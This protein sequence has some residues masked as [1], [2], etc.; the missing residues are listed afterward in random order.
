MSTSVF[1]T[2]NSTVTIDE[3]TSTLNA[4]F[5]SSNFT[6]NEARESLN[7]SFDFE[8]EKEMERALYYSVRDKRLDNVTMVK[9]GTYCFN[10][11]KPESSTPSTKNDNKVEMTTIIPS[12]IA[13][14]DNINP[15]QNF[16][17]EKNKTYVPHGC[18]SVI[19]KVIK[20]NAFAPMWI[21]G[22]PGN[23]KT[24]GVEQACAQEKRELILVN[25][26]N[27]TTEEDLIGSYILKDGSLVW[28]DGPVTVAMRRGAVLLLDE[29][30]QARN[31]VMCLN[32]IL[33]NKPYFIKKTNEVVK[34]QEG[35]CVIATANTKGDGTGLDKFAGA[36][37]LNDAFLDRFSIVIEQDFP[38][39]RVE[40][41]ILNHVCD[42]KDFNKNLVEL[43]NTIRKAYSDGEMDFVI[44]TRRL[45]QI[46]N[47]YNVFEDEVLSITYGV[48]RFSKIDQDAII[49]L[50]KAMVADGE[51]EEDGED[52]DVNG[53]DINNVWVTIN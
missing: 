43:A 52:T 26:S 5:E 23:G 13:V 15:E 11:Q 10:S 1:A 47:N 45:C 40:R 9:R 38:E 12:D 21:T 6:L 34:P 39:A 48:A 37:V 3:I 18:Y 30:D 46:A 20:A 49:E 24:Y 17:P 16:V 19:R 28:R 2:K 36:Q 27:E 42:N 44:S 4:K 33:Q 35:F 8:S 29:V 50:Y 41:K 31:S 25:I 51:E 14:V 22:E 32:T 7:S 53:I